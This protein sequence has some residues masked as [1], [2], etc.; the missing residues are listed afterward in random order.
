MIK[1]METGDARQ[2]TRRLIH[3]VNYSE[4]IRV[5]AVQD[6][7]SPVAVA[8]TFLGDS[9]STMG[10]A[11]DRSVFR[12]LQPDARWLVYAAGFA[13][14]G[15]ANILTIDLVYQSAAVGLILLGSTT[16]TGAGFVKVGFGPFDVFTP[17]GPV[18]PTEAIPIIRLGARKNVG[19]TG[20]LAVWNI[21]L[22]L[23]APKQ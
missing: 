17:G 4:E 16:R 12:R 7:V 5:V 10:L 13:D 11:V 14:P 21:W 1:V 22:R 15:D 23:L 20:A 3:S 18:A 2:D 19:A 6:P 8:A 9:Y